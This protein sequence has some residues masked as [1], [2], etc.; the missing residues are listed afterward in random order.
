M[1]KS[2]TNRGKQDFMK[3]PRSFS[4]VLRARSR[5]LFAVAGICLLA[6]C[7]TYD[8]V[9]GSG[10]DVTATDS[11]RLTRSGFLSDYE[12]L[13]PVAANDNI[14]CWRDRRIDFKKYDKVL[15]SRI[16]VSL[17]QPV[18]GKVPEPV[19]PT[20]LKVLTDYFHG[21]LVR[22]LEPQ[23]PVVQQAGQGVVVI[24]IALTDLVPTSIARSAA[25]TLTPYGFVAEAGSGVATGR[26]AGS[27]PYLGETGMEMQFVDGGNGSILGECRDTQIGRKYA[28]AID[29]NAVGAAQTWASGYINSFQAWSYAKNAF[30]K[31]AMLLARRLTELRGLAP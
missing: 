1:R 3:N 24:R 4:P 22:A 18:D 14:A 17:S 26:P 5:M 10:A 9:M 25:G 30:D 6:G 23:M 16:V 2:K 8:T 7:Q 13:A 28:A 21:A 29:A 27:T 15:I 31:W 20:D 19:D 11:K 12:R